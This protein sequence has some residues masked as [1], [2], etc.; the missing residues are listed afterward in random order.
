MDKQP[1]ILRGVIEVFTRANDLHATIDE[2]LSSCFC[3]AELS[4]LAGERAVVRKLDSG[5]VT[6]GAIADDS[7]VSRTPYV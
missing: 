6:T 7:V 2:L 3:R 1:E 4:L 5:C